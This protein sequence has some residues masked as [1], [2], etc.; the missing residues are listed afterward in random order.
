M[1]DPR[2]TISSARPPDNRSSVTKFWNTR[3][4]SAELST[5]TALDSL[6]VFVHP[7]MVARTISG[8]DAAM[9]GRWCS[10]MP[11]T[12]RPSSSASLASATTCRSRS[13]GDK[14]GSVISAN[15][16]SPSSM[17]A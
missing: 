17:A 12:S 2:P 8:A 3:T 15:V 6:I 5:I 14:F 11:K 16:V 4:G 7:A 9:S 1:N 10:P 13:P